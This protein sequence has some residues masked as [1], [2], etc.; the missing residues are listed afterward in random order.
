[1]RLANQKQMGTTVASKY[2]VICEENRLRYG[3]EGAKKS[4]GLATDLYDDR[5]HFI[6]ELLQNSEDANGRR[7]IGNESRKV[8]FALTQTSLTLSHFGKPFDEAD[9]RSV[10]DIAESTKNESSI[11]RFGLG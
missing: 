3:T 10:C 2:E 6:F 9:V 7:R 8:A 4:G 1:M 11:G 5:M